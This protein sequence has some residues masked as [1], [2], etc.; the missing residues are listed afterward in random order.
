MLL[1]L[2]LL[3]LIALISIL[4]L[5]LSVL[6]KVVL[7]FIVLIMAIYTIKQYALLKS[8]NSIYKLRCSSNNKCQ[9]ELKNGKV[10]QAKLISAEWLFNYFAVLLLQNNTKK[11]KATIAKDSMSQEQLYALRLYLRSFNK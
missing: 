4:F 1:S 7:V 5:S 8:E 9:I 6:F 2:S 3:Y 11:F 10:L